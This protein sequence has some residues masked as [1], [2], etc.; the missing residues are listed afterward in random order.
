MVQS[1][2]LSTVSVTSGRIFSTAEA[3]LSSLI[4]MTIF[5][6]GLLFR[7]EE[8]ETFRAMISAAIKFSRD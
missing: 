5:T 4:G 6:N 2:M 1:S 3:K 7:I 8:D